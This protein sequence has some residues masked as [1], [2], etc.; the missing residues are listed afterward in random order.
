VADT[1]LGTTLV[2]F[3]F[4]PPEARGVVL[5]LLER[6]AALLP[7]W[8]HVLRVQWRRG[9]LAD[10]PD[11]TVVASM[12][13]LPQYRDAT[14]KVSA[15]F[16]EEHPQVRDDAM[17]HELFHLH[18]QPLLDVFRGARDHLK[19]TNKPLADALGDRFDYAL[20]GVVSDLARAVVPNGGSTALTAAKRG[21]ARAAGAPGRRP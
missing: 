15:A 9:D 8:L 17:A 14:L 13:A 4:M 19:R 16:L 1:R 7:T 10:G 18:V 5:A 11:V 2:V 6:H 12:S 20:E 21:R 3:E